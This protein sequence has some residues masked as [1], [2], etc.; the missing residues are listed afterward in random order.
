L[1]L[2]EIHAA[3]EALR[4]FLFAGVS[5]KENDTQWRNPAVVT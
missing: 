3:P 2:N 1:K 5:Y 4:G